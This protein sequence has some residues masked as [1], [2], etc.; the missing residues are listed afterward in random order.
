MSI[1][2]PRTNIKRR[3]NEHTTGFGT[4]EHNYRWQR[5]VTILQTPHN[6]CEVARVRS[7]NQL[8]NYD[9]TNKR[10]S[11]GAELPPFTGTGTGT[12]INRNRNMKTSRESY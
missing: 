9:K 10:G 2:L 12:E 4:G 7:N 11:P 6:I 1:Y 5:G 8:P 3:T